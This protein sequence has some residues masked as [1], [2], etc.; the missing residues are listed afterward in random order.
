MFIYLIMSFRTN[1]RQSQC[2]NFLRFVIFIAFYCLKLF[3]LFHLLHTLYIIDIAEIVHYIFHVVEHDCI[4]TR[5][6]MTIKR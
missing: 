2:G 4:T 6:C 3:R 1:T 5:N